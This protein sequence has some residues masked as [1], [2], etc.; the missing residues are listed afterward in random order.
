MLIGGRDRASWE[1]HFGGSD[2]GWLDEYCE[3]VDGLR[4]GWWDSIHLLVDS[5]MWEC[6]KVT[7]PLSSDGEVVDGGQSCQEAPRKRKLHWGVNSFSWEGK[8]DKQSW[9]DTVLGVCYAQCILYSVYVVLA[10]CST[11]CQL[12]LMAWTD[13]EGWFNFEF[14]DDGTVVDKKVK[15][16]GWRWER[17]GGYEGTWQ[18][19]DITS[20][21][22]LGR[23]RIGV[24]TRR[25][26]NPT[27]HIRDGT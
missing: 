21:I 4:I 15:D 6:D 7:L 20:H 2:R 24:I 10:V 11:R 3:P 26:G 12:M 25:I 19:R 9:V 27:Y 18:N 13:R 17:C 23:P 14:C 22:G 16:G 5:Q 1:K 8:D